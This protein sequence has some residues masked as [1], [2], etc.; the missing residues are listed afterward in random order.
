MVWGDPIDHLVPTSLPWARTPSTTPGCSSIRG[1]V[2]HKSWCVFL[3]L[4]ILLWKP[5]FKESGARLHSHSREESL[6]IL[7]SAPFNTLFFCEIMSRVVGLHNISSCL[8][9]PPLSFLKAPELCSTQPNRP[10]P[11]PATP[12]LAQTTKCNA[13]QLPWGCPRVSTPCGVLSLPGPVGQDGR[14]D[15]QAKQQHPSPQGPGGGYHGGT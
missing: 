5:L 7:F 4:F 9:H 12:A 3:K 8:L 14:Q 15:P 13:A 1:N 11:L 6:S 10:H 2:K